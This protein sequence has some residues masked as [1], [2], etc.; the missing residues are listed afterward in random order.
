LKTII[1]NQHDPVVDDIDVNIGSDEVI[2]AD[3]DDEKIFVD[4]RV[5]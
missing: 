3:V 4:S 2:D 1:I 5:V